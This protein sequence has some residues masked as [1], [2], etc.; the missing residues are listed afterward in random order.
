MVSPRKTSL[1]STLLCASNPTTPDTQRAHTR[2]TAGYRFIVTG[3]EKGPV[4]PAPVCD[5]GEGS[6]ER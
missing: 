3:C 2:D 5:G 6:E 4:W 1:I